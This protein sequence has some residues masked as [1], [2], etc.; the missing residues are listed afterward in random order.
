MSNGNQEKQSETE[1]LLAALLGG[2]GQSR[3]P[4][5]WQDRLVEIAPYA[6]SAVGSGL[7]ARAQGKQNVDQMI[8]DQERLRLQE[9]GLRQQQAAVGANLMSGFL[10]GAD[11]RARMGLA[12]T[13]MDPYAQQKSLAR[14]QMFNQQAPLGSTSINPDLTTSG[15][16]MPEGGYNLQAISPN[17]L[18]Q[19]RD[20]FN[21]YAVGAAPGTS[22][23][24]GSD[25]VNAAQ[26]ARLNQ[27]G[28]GEQNIMNYLEGGAGG[29]AG[30]APSS[31]DDGSGDPWWIQQQRRLSRQPEPEN[32][33]GGGSWWR[34]LA[35]IAAPFA[36]AIPGFG[37]PISMG[38]G[39]LAGSGG[40]LKGAA[41]GAGGAALGGLAS[42]GISGLRGRQEPP[43]PPPPGYR[44]NIGQGLSI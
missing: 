30:G 39:A 24:G 2:L 5:T 11:D 28:S 16:G 29:G 27:I 20:Q 40:G 26:Q 15:G 32:Q 12:S 4:K 38:L 23:L 35:G 36:A 1:R 37:I 34:R 43:P 14:L 7:E 44:S 9:Q 21:L 19:A 41:L 3:A 22:I 13:Q 18:A 31:L 8:L 42:R 33:G 17:A 25:A 10:S 6:M